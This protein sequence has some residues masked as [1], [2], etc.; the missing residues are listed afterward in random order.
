MQRYLLFLLLILPGALYSQSILYS[1][2][3]KMPAALAGIEVIGK[4]D[5]NF[6]V[7]QLIKDKYQL[8]VF[9]SNM[10][11]QHAANL[12]F[13]P[14]S[15]IRMTFVPYKK[16]L[17]LIYQGKENNYTFCRIAMLDKDGVF[18]NGITVDS[19]RSDVYKGG[20]L[21][22]V[23]TSVNKKYILFS[24]LL[25]GFQTGKLQVEQIIVNNELVVVNKDK[26]LI[27][28]NPKNTSVS[29][30]KID[31]QR[32]VLFLTWSNSVSNSTSITIYKL[33]NNSDDL[34]SRELA[35]RKNVV[36][37]PTLEIDNLNQVYHITSFYEDGKTMN[38][39]GLFSLLLKNDLSDHHPPLIYP[40]N[41]SVRIN[42]NAR[43]ELPAAFNDYFIKD[44]IFLSGGKFLVS[45]VDG[46]NSLSVK[47]TPVRHPH[48]PI[49]PTILEMPNI[50]SE[51]GKRILLFGNV[52]TPFVFQGE[53]PK[54]QVLT[55]SEVVTRGN[56][57]LFSLDGFNKV[58]GIKHLSR[59][60]EM[61]PLLP[62]YQVVNTGSKVFFIYNKGNMKKSLLNSTSLDQNNDLL[63]NFLNK[64]F[65]KG[66]TFMPS[67]SKQ[68][69]SKIMVIPF[70]SGRKIGYASIQ[71]P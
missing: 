36:K 25:S 27:P 24:R 5:N 60:P 33:P 65:D 37:L 43:G 2:P 69:D 30:L 4:V 56:V 15:I 67:L 41:D 6:L 13:L 40:F 18:L 71:F 61:T 70:L 23:T 58:T 39:S 49:A 20:E 11:L 47:S 64:S 45:A 68:V 12:N 14:S 55:N 57:V 31:D 9:G 35:I 46:E 44:I 54:E 17:L 1:D 10:E 7:G 8:E 50:Y 59:N 48:Q 34:I 19:I 63:V 51:D 3:Q 38:V 26:Y 66:Y 32:N 62:Y 28:Y 16:S 21:Y 53:N 42:V 29:D 22:D 52:V